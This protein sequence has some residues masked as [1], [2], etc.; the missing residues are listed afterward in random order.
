[1]KQKG[2]DGVLF[3]VYFKDLDVVQPISDK[4][5]KQYD[6]QVRTPY[7]IFSVYEIWV[8]F[9]KKTPNFIADVS[10]MGRGELETIIW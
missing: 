4:L 1:M 3:F 10:R 5:V 2:Y 9:W 6:P 8:L 7:R